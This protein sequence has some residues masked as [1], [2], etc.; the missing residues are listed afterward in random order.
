VVRGPWSVVRGP[1]V[2]GVAGPLL[3]CQGESAAGPRVRPDRTFRLAVQASSPPSARSLV[4]RPRGSWHKSRSAAP[5]WQG[6]RS[7]NIGHI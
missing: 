7:E 6:A 2:H 3:T 1:W 5:G 4:S